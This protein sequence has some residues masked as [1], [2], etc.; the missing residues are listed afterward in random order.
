VGRWGGVS[1]RRRRGGKKRKNLASLP[2]LIVFFLTQHAHLTTSKYKH[3]K[4]QTPRSLSTSL[5]AMPSGM[6]R[7]MLRWLARH[8]HP[9][10]TPIC[11]TRERSLRASSGLHTGGG[12]AVEEVNDRYLA[13]VGWRAATAATGTC[14]DS[15]SSRWRE[16][17]RSRAVFMQTVEVG[18]REASP[19]RTAPDARVARR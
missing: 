10:R 13:L 12:E 11:N 14:C 16:G 6:R 5:T 4:P 17:A 7:W 19:V 8:N 2:I 1:S 15:G 18:H 3:P 9:T